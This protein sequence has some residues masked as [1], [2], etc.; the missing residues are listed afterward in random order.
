[1]IGEVLAGKHLIWSYEHSAWWRAN[2]CGYTGELLAAGLYDKDEADRIVE[3]ANKFLPA[4][5]P[6]EVALPA[7]SVFGGEYLPAMRG[8]VLA[9]LLDGLAKDSGT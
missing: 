1:M 5:K 7:S 2:R 8:T 6:N 4:G 3:A 9:A